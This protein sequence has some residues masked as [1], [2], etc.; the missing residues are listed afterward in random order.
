MS[1]LELGT[2]LTPVISHFASPI[3]IL[4]VPSR[5]YLSVVLVAEM[6]F[7][8]RVEFIWKSIEIRQVEES[9]EL[10]IVVF[11]LGKVLKSQFY[12]I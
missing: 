8:R 1:E 3:Q 7:H 5:T 10:H 6:L 2:T 4:P 9:Q 12:F 11:L